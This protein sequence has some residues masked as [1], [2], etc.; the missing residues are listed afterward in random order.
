LDFLYEASTLEIVTNQD[1]RRLPNQESLVATLR[2]VFPHLSPW[3]EA[4]GRRRGGRIAGEAQLALVDPKSYERSRNYLAGDVTRLSAYLRHGVLT[5]AEVR[6]ELLRRVADPRHAG[7]LI[8]ELAWRDYWQRIY[9][10]IGE[11]VWHDREQYKTGYSAKDYATALPA[12][13]SDG[14][15][16]LAC[17]DGFAH[18][19]TDTGYLHNHARMWFAAYVVHWRR[20][21]WQAGA[22]WFLEHLLDGDPASNNLS[23]QWVASTFASKAY[24]F[25]REN[26]ERY[27]NGVYCSNCP[28]AKASTCPFDQDYE[29]LEQTLFPRLKFSAGSTVMPTPPKPFPAPSERR[30]SQEPTGK[31][32]LWVHTDSL[33]PNSPMLLAH[34][35]A[36]AVFIW[37]AA[38]LKGSRIALKRIVF[39]AECL[40]EMPGTIELRSGDLADELLLAAK[41]CGADYI[42]VQQTPDPRLRAAALATDQHLPVIWYDPPPFVEEMGRFDLKRFSRYWQRAEISAMKM[43]NSTR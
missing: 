1:M 27:T 20:I 13:I 32:L 21:R 33:N 23:W 17:I 24:F 39:I 19:L 9:W 29:G 10:Q 16:T 8:N 22:R 31:P 4:L 26:L 34:P 15:T 28:H 42:L 37:D 14:T 30:S 40:K 25:N 18:E 6:D 11:G 7:K 41:T 3:D 12:D 38:W 5:L 2:A 35:D 43:T 36:P